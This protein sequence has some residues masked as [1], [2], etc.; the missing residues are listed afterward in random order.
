MESV[1]SS[2]VDSGDRWFCGRKMY[3][4][5]L[6]ELTINVSTARSI[7]DDDWLTF[8]EDT[9]AISRGLRVSTKVS[10]IC[11]VCAYPNA[12]QRMVASE[13]LVRHRLEK[14]GRVAAVTDSIMVRGAVTAFSWI[15]PK[16]RVSAFRS[17]DAGA[18]IHWL[19]EAGAFDESQALLAW[20]DAQTKLGMRSGV[21]IRPTPIR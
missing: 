2:M 4:R 17:A 14:I 5:Q 19:H 13:F 16:L 15:M 21:S 6:D 18:A 10:L 11:C 9:L 20:H 12:R 3:F 7:D 8:L 1:A